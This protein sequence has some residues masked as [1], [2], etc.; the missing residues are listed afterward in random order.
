MYPKIRLCVKFS[1]TWLTI[2]N[3]GKIKMYTSGCPKN[4]NSDWNNIGSPPENGSKKL[5]LKFLS[6][7]S[8]VMAPAK[9]GNDS[10]NKKAVINIVQTNKG[11]IV[12]YKP[13]QRILQIVTIKFIAPAIEDTPAKCKL[14]IAKS[15]A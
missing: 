8:I 13:K 1:I 10:N 3:A 14:N 15:T 2:P 4:Q 6:N 5:L 11:I 12:I 7:K 9:T